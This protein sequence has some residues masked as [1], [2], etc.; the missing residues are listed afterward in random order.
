MCAIKDVCLMSGLNGLLGDIELFDM[1]AWRRNGLPVLPWVNRPVTALVR[2]CRPGAFRV[3]FGL[4]VRCLDHESLN[5]LCRRP[6][7]DF[8]LQHAAVRFDDPR[9]SGV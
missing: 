1:T 9:R 8:R 3:P 7:F 5:I 6:V 4:F 2:L